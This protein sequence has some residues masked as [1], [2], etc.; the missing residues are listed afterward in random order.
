MA[1]KSWRA[2]YLICPAVAAIALFASVRW[3]PEARASQTTP[4]D[5]VG[6]TL[7]AIGLVAML[8]GISGAATGGWTGAGVVVPLAIASVAL[9]AFI[10][11]ELRASHPA[12]PIRLFAERELIAAALS[13]FGWC[14]ANGVII[15]QLS[16]LWQY[17]YRYVPLRVSLGQLPLTI[18]SIAGAALAG[19][20][21]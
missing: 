4:F 11:F 19:R 2:A 14:F 1:D 12:F 20:L 21:S 18:A 5:Y 13:Q 6:N 7:I 15:L 16:L 8:R 10:I 3:V 9:A 17:V